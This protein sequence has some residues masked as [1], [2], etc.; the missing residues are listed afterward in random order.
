M[1]N[2]LRAVEARKLNEQSIGNVE[3]KLFERI[4]SD[5]EMGYLD[6]TLYKP[7]ENVENQAMVNYCLSDEGRTKL[8]SLG[9]MV[10]DENGVVTISW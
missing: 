3:E 9:Y 1:T 10:T 5:A 2:F 8:L 4:K 6:T 7:I